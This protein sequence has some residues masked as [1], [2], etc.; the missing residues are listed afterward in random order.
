MRG[1]RL[2]LSAAAA[3][4]LSC[5]T[6]SLAR[7]DE[8]KAE[9]QGVRRTWYAGAYWGWG[10]HEDGMRSALDVARALGCVP[11]RPPCAQPARTALLPEA[12]A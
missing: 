6:A 12:T 8:P 2:V 9:I 3:T 4:L 11:S 5:G 7:A 1:L 10:F